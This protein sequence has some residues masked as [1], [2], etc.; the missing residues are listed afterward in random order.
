MSQDSLQAQLQAIVS[1]VR[2]LA[3]SCQGDNIAILAVLRQL[4]ELHREIRDGIFQASLPDNRQALYALLRDIESQ[5]GWPYI[6]RMRIQALLANWETA[7]RNDRSGN[8]TSTDIT[9]PSE[10]HNGEV[11]IRD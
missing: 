6:E 4:E 3:A 9:K 8:E 7:T 11:T 10:A 2:T 5:G 1:A